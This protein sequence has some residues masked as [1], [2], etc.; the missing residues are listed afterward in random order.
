MANKARQMAAALLGKGRSMRGAPAGIRDEYLNDPRR[1]FADQMLLEGTDASPVRHPMEGVARLAK[2]LTGAYQSRQLRD[3]YGGRSEEYR[4][5]LA[6]ALAPSVVS[7][8]TEPPGPYRPTADRQPTMA[9]FGQRLAQSGN[10]DLSDLAGNIALQGMQSREQAAASEAEAMRRYQMDLGKEKYRYD[11]GQQPMPDA[12]MR[13]EIELARAKAQAGQVDPATLR[14]WQAYKSLPAPELQ[15]EFLRV[16]RADKVID[17]GGQIINVTPGMPE[18]AVTVAEKTLPP[19]NQPANV[20]AEA[21]A[22]AAG[23]AK[24]KRDFNM[25]G[26]GDIIDEARD[27]LQGPVKPTSSGMGT[28]YD[29][30]AGFVGVTPE[31]ASEAEA[32]RAIGGSLVAKMPRMEGPQSNY[33]VQNYREMAG[34]VGDSTIPIERRLKALDAVER[35]WKKYEPAGASPGQVA[36]TVP[37]AA[38]IIVDY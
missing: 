36:P 28:L 5:A 18:S 1:Q 2:A 38:P 16:M 12:K 30:A 8:E 37:F 32:L 21:A 35:L 15:Q 33:D 22:Q 27:V 26:I 17:A 7:R 20:A 3:E 10:P 25:M 4:K 6:A 24:G 14:V 23:A 9:E 34:Q 31:G 29:T 13:Q 19:Q 11:L